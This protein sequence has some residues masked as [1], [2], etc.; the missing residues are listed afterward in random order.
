MKKRLLLLSLAS[1]SLS[2]D[3]IVPAIP[4][5]WNTWTVPLSSRSAGFWD[6]AS[7]DGANCNIG[8]WLLGTAGSGCVNALGNLGSPPP[9]AL[10]YMSAASDNRTPVQFSV[11]PNPVGN[12]RLMTLHLKVSGYNDNNE[13]GYYLLSQPGVLNPLFRGTNKPGDKASIQPTGPFAF[14]IKTGGGLTFTSQA[15]NN[16]A[17]FSQTPA[18]PA[19]AATDL[20]KYYVGVEDLPIPPPPYTTPQLFDPRTDADYNDM[21]VDMEVPPPDPPRPTGCTLTQGGYKNNFNY[22]VIQAAGVALGSVGYTPAQVNTILGTPVRGNGLVSLAHQ[23]ITAKLNIY[24]GASAPAE[25]LTAIQQSDALIGSLVVPNVG[26]GSLLP[27]QTSS[28][29]S[30]LDAFNNGLLGTPHCR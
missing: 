30:V 23:L 3:V 9:G 17:I 4:A 6:A 22:L 7:Y 8:Y 1:L 14:Y 28:L 18:L 21:V 26:L 16:F 10:A 5:K 24:Y 13:F 29:A 19:T 20:T 25:V 27:S 11:S 15:T 2:A 12:A